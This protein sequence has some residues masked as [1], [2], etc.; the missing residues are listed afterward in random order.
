MQVTICL[1]TSAGTQ[2]PS[3]AAFLNTTATYTHS[4]NMMPVKEDEM[5]DRNVLKVY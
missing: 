5:A 2:Q 4:H 1:A 3:H